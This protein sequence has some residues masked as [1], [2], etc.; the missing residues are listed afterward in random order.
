MPEG[1]Y[2]IKINIKIGH[3]PRKNFLKIQKGYT[4]VDK[5]AV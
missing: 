2:L 4:N 3:A 1:K 5:H